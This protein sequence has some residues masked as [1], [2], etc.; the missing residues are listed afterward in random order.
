M[1]HDSMMSR[2]D[3]LE[4]YFGSDDEFPSEEIID[5]DETDTN[6]THGTTTVEPR[7]DLTPI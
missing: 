4:R 1:E 2:I 6:V 7:I 5:T 3:E